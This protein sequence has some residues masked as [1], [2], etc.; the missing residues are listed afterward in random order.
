MAIGTSVPDER[1]HIAAS[2]GSG[3]GSL[4]PPADVTPTA[5]ASLLGS[6]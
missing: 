2:S 4:L 1:E 5:S 3:G 6:G